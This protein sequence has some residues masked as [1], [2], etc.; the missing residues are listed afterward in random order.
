MAF[1]RRKKKVVMWL[2]G[3]LVIILLIAVGIYFGYG[4]YLQN[5][6]S[7]KKSYEGQI[8]TYQEEFAKR[9]RV[10]LFPVDSIEA[11]SKIDETMLEQKN[12][13]SDVIQDGF[14]SKEDVGQIALVDL[15]V[16]QPVYKNMLVNETI[17]DD[18]REEEFSVFLLSSNLNENSY[19]DLRIGFPNGEDYIVLSKK[20]V[21]DIDLTQKTIWL[22]LGEEDIL[23]VSSAIVDAYLHEGSKLYTVVYVKPNIQ[24]AA[25]ITYPVNGEVLKLINENPN[26]L[27]EAKSNLLGEVRLPLDERLKAMD[28]ELRQKMATERSKE[29]SQRDAVITENEVQKKIEAEQQAIQETTDQTT[30]DEK[31]GEGWF[32]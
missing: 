10:G 32:E 21:R 18:L 15:P 28:E 17:E 2:M 27:L 11:G 12:I 25:Q 6:E 30:G 22:W 24:K 20:K 4:A 9:G 8:K 19:V 3:I 31:K 29:S 5:I 14:M 1:T 26:I 23:R 7:I 13:I 16:G